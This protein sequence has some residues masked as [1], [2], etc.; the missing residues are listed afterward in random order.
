MLNNIIFMMLNFLAKNKV[1][2]S[3]CSY[4]CDLQGSFKVW[5]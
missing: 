1:W 2:F 4:F 3:I 5:T